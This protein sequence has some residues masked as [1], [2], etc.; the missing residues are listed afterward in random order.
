MDTETNV[1]AVETSTSTET[2]TE[3]ENKTYTQD[4]LDAIVQREADRRVSK[5]LKTAEAKFKKAQSEADKLRDMDET[6]R[7][8]FEYQ[9][10]IEELEQKERDFAIM[11]NKVE[12]S[13]IME[14]RGLP[15]SFVDYVVSET[16]DEMKDKI[17]AF[18]KEWKSAIQDAVSKR[19]GGATPKGAVQQT[20]MTKDDFNKLTLAQRQQLYQ[21]NPTLY[22]SLV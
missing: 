12:A 2:T 8:E 18:E 5:A 7:R 21:T 1:G 14:K 15:V 3:N 4:E 13:K 10:R 17:D 20:G 22:N 9:K 6:Q 19:L 11:S 16:A